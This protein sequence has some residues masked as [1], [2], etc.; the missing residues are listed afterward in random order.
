MKL[1]IQISP[2]PLITTSVEIRFTTKDNINI[3]SNLIPVLL[4]ELPILDNIGLPQA[5]RNQQPDL[6]Y[7]PDIRL[8]NENL[9]FLLVNHQSYLNHSAVIHYGINILVL[10]KNNTLRFLILT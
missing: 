5:I 6:E 4:S 7:Q 3:V 10:F 1:P 2:N 9:R 8:R